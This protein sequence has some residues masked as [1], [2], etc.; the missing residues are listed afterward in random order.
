VRRT[1]A[2][3]YSGGD[4]A[5]VEYYFGNLDDRRVTWSTGRDLM[6][7]PRQEAGPVNALPKAYVEVDGKVLPEGAAGWSRKLTFREKSGA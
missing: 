2:D 7:S 3:G 5:K 4:P 6:L 1:T